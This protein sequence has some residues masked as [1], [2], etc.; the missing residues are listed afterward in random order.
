MSLDD[1]DNLWMSVIG[2]AINL[3]VSIGEAFM[4]AGFDSA[5]KVDAP[6]P[7]RRLP[8]NLKEKD[9]LKFQDMMMW[10]IKFKELGEIWELSNFRVTYRHLFLRGLKGVE[11]LITAAYLINL[12][13]VLRIMVCLRAVLENGR[14]R[15]RVS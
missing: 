3:D 13:R 11:K 10:L 5:T 12:K 9:H 2:S 15:D 14:K 7:K 1:S 4:A 6:A 8:S